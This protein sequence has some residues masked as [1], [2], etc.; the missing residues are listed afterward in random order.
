MFLSGYGPV[1]LSGTW[2]TDK[3]CFVIT[4]TFNHDWIVWG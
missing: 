3:A 2:I 4:A 1:L